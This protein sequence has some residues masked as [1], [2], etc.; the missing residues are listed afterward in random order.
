MRL[1]DLDYALPPEQIA[2]RPLSNRDA[3]RMLVLDPISGSHEDHMFAEF[4]A[5]LRGDE[6]LVV[7]NARV[8]PARL[9]GRRVVGTVSTEGEKTSAE[10]SGGEVEVLLSRQ[11][12]A[13]NW[14]ALVRP[15]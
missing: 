9:L 12:D 8:I 10:I 2:Q 3:S 14:E 15:G 5:L 1:S 7:N 13:A 4:P 6:L 11:L